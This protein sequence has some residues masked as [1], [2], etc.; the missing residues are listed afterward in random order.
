LKNRE[1]FVPAYYQVADDLKGQIESGT[2]KP[3]DMIPSEFRLGAEYGI[4]RM[5]VRRGLALL[6]ESGMIKT[7]RGKG[8]FVA[9]PNW[10]QATM[11]FEEDAL[12]GDQ[13]AK[14]KLVEISITKAE[15]EIAA[16]LAVPEGTKIF[17]IKRLI[18]SE[19]GP[20]GIDIK[21]IPYLKRKPILENEIEYAYF[22][23][24]VANH[25]D[26]MIYKIERCISAT[27]LQPDEAKILQTDMGH[28]VLCITQ[29][30]YAKNEKPLGIS[31]TIYQGD[32]F[33]LKTVSYPYSG[34]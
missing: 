29:A 12:A 20:V 23:D 19:S 28:P 4:S 5:T 7:I 32:A 24:I 10:R 9:R 3:G 34:A 27:S 11:T 2:L 21:Y 33:G 8:N 25:T 6:L 22:P 1:D 30:I 18:S 17:M 13:K 16:K 26:I 15:G 31:K 14:F